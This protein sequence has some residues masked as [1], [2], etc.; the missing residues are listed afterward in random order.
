MKAVILSAGKGNRLLP[1]TNNMPKCLIEVGG[2]PILG[3]Q[4][5]ALET[6]GVQ[7]IA[8]VTGYLHEQIERFLG[9]RYTVIV[10]EAYEA[11]N[12]IFSLWL[13]RPFA[14]GQ[15]FIVVNGDIVFDAELLT[16]L[17]CCASPTA[18]LVDPNALIRDGEMN[19]V[20]KAGRIIRF[21]KEIPASEASAQSLQ[22]TKFGSEDSKRLFERIRNLV[23]V[24]A[25]DKFPASAYDV[26]LRASTMVPV[27]RRRGLWYEIDT[28]DDLHE[29][30]RLM[31]SIDSANS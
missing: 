28:L 29:V 8:V 6:C 31:L 18:A 13:A 23:E 27:V 22:I 24:G 25:V 4:L 10:N 26:V 11:T 5:R 16:P 12:S 21:S 7:D 19:V 1:Y 17:V 2:M 3:H 9:G 14:E 15:D 20:I 30:R